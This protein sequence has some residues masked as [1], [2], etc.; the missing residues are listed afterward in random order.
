MDEQIILH[1]APRIFN[2][3]LNQSDPG[4]YWTPRTTTLYGNR[5]KLSQFNKYSRNE[6]RFRQMWH[7]LMKRIRHIVNTLFRQR[8]TYTIITTDAINVG[9]F[10]NCNNLCTVKRWG[11]PCKRTWRPIRLWDVDWLPHFLDNRLTDDGEI[12]SLTCWPPFI[13]QEDSSYSYLLAP[14]STAGPQCGWITYT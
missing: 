9:N 2:T 3:P 5:N 4:L 7:L 14:E 12:V 11:Y 8:V 1:L 10:P 6:E 13:R